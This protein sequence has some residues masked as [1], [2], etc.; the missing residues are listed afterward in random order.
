[1]ILTTTPTVAGR[2]IRDHKGLVTAEAIMGAHIGRDIL[3]GLRDFFGGRSKA[4]ENVIMEAKTTAIR[5]LEERAQKLGADAI[6]GID[7]DFETVGQRGSMLMVS[8]SG[9]AVKLK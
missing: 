2:E 3:A 5:E 8:I 6:V 9:T 7:F 1:M 4:Y